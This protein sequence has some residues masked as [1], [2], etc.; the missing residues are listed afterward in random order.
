VLK[1]ADILLT[2]DYFVFMLTEVI[3]AQIGSHAKGEHSPIGY[4]YYDRNR[5]EWI[6]VGEQEIEIQIQPNKNG[7]I[8]EI[9]IVYLTNDNQ[10]ISISI[11]KL[12]KDHLEMLLDAQRDESGMISTII[13]EIVS[14]PRNISDMLAALKASMS[15]YV[16]LLE[17]NGTEPNGRNRGLKH[18]NLDGEVLYLSQIGH[19][20]LKTAYLRPFQLGILRII[21]KLCPGYLYSEEYHPSIFR[22][23]DYLVGEGF[24]TEEYGNKIKEYYEFLLILYSQ[25]KQEFYYQG[26]GDRE[27]EAICEYRIDSKTIEKLQEIRGFIQDDFTEFVANANPSQRQEK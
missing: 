26:Y 9:F 22:K 17:E 27:K 15:Y 16:T 3:E 8:H 23:V 13:K 4:M 25:H 11:Q 19:R 2:Q 12:I 5:Q 7:K 10:I 1:Y 14:T 20:S 21:L 24:L 6:T 18:Y